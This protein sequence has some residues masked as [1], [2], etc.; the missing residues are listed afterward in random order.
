MNMFYNYT[1]VNCAQAQGHLFKRKKTL[2]IP[3]TFN[4]FDLFV[5]TNI[6][7]RNKTQQ[8]SPL[9]F[10]RSV[11]TELLSPTSVAGK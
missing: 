10:W 9:T 3:F 5:I 6:F 2:S 1:L 11:V 7:R 8:A 4:R